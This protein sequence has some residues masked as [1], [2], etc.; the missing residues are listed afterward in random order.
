MSTLRVPDNSVPCVVPIGERQLSSP[1]PKC[2]LEKARRGCFEC[3]LSPPRAQRGDEAVH[4]SLYGDSAAKGDG[5]VNGPATATAQRAEFV[6][7]ESGQK[8]L[9]RSLSRCIREYSDWG[10][11]PP[12][13]NESTLAAVRKRD[14]LDGRRVVRAF[15][16]WL[17]VGWIVR[18]WQAEKQSLT[19]SGVLTLPGVRTIL[20]YV[21]SGMEAGAA[22]R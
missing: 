19:G 7:E 9:K 22:L 1:S 10:L 12:V 6:P 2:C 3:S 17:A 4:S 20:V 5:R 13:Q 11:L 16:L 8:G 14:G 15:P 18:K 21:H